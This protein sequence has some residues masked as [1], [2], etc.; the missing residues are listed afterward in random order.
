MASLGTWHA[1]ECTN[2]HAGKTLHI[3][4]FTR[5]RERKRRKERKKER[6]KGRKEG[7]KE[8]RKKRKGKERKENL[9]CTL[10]VLK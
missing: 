2:I 6:K 10:M 7:R 3:K 1:S 5:E 8:E 4:V 9:V